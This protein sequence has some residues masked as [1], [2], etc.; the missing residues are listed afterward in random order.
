M[1]KLWI[2]WARTKPHRA[3]V[4]NWPVYRPDSSKWPTL[5]WTEAW[6]FEVINLLVAEL[7]IKNAY[8]DS[9]NSKIMTQIASKTFRNIPLPGNV[10]IHVL[11]LFVLHLGTVFENKLV[12][13]AKK[14]K[15]IRLKSGKRCWSF[16]QR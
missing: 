7:Q 3:K 10:K 4:E 11:S 2:T 9:L 5:I 6:S 8:V 16:T 1:K 14:K 12:L 15:K 13:N